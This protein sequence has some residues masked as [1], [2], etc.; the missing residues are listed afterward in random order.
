MQR[1]VRNAA[2]GIIAAFIR[3][4][5]AT[6]RYRVVGF[7]RATEVAR[8]RGGFVLAV[9]HEA[10]MIGLGHAV[11]K[12]AVALVSPGPDGTFAARLVAPFGVASVRGSRSR[13]GA[14]GVRA[15]LR[16][17]KPG[18]AVVVTPDGPR[19]PR[20]VAAEGVAYVASRAGL[21]VVALGVASPRAKRL[22]SWDRFCIPRPFGAAHLVFAAPI[23][24][25]PD[26]DRPALAAAAKEIEA[27]LKAA[28]R[29]ACDAAGVPDD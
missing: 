24:V 3:L 27:A 5:L 2:A 4:L 19:G 20:R 14:V 23:D 1:T 6:V 25:P 16:A 12:D 10:I 17:R 11:R 13:D 9:W 21:P 28:T 8:L 22:R 29:A 15:L 7:E 26:A 18:G